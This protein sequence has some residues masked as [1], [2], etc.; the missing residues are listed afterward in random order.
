MRDQ[1][2]IVF[3][4][5]R[6]RT[7]LDYGES[8][9]TVVKRKQQRIIRAACQYLL[10]TNAFDKVYGRFDVLGLD[11]TGTVDWIKNAF[12]VQY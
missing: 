1:E 12:E 2:T 5:V 8:S 6:Y 4:E 10:E 11:R 9:E 7:D 3:I